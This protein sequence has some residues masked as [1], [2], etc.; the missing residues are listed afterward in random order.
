MAP[1]DDG[2]ISNEADWV[3][4]GSTHAHHVMASRRR[5]DSVPSHV[6]LILAS[7]LWN[8]S[9][10]MNGLVYGAYSV[11][12]PASSQHV[13]RPCCPHPATPFFPTDFVVWFARIFQGNDGV[14]NA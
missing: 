5:V 2:R 9:A 4:K 7:L 14:D 11:V 1:A 10:A 6:N 8:T 13:I 12:S 3:L